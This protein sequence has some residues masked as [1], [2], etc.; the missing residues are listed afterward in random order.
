V[1]FD[2]SELLVSIN[3]GDDDREF[4]QAM[5][6]DQLHTWADYTA[7]E[8]VNGLEHYGF[9]DDHFAVAI[10]QDKTREPGDGNK[11]VFKKQVSQLLYESL[12]RAGFTESLNENAIEEVTTFLVNNQLSKINNTNIL[13]IITYL[14]CYDV[15]T[16]VNLFK[17]EMRYESTTGRTSAAAQYNGNISSITWKTSNQ[18]ENEYGH[19]Y[20]KLNRL[21]ASDYALKSGSSWTN[22]TN[23]D[24]NGISY[25][26]NGNLLSMTQYGKINTGN[27]YNKIDALTYR[28]DG[29]RLL[30]VTDSEPLASARGDFE[31][32]NK[33]TDD[34]SYDANGNLI[35]D[36]N[37]GINITYNYL[38]M[39]SKIVFANGNSIYYIYNTNGTKMR[40]LHTT[41]IA[42]PTAPV[43]Q[44]RTD[45]V[46]GFVYVNNELDFF[47]NETG[48]VLKVSGGFERQYVIA[49][50]LGNARMS[51][52]PN[53]N[54]QPV[55]L[56]YDSYYPFGL[57]MGGMSFVSSSE[58]KYKYNGK[59]KQTAHN[60]GWYDYGA[61]FY[62][63][64]IGRWHVVDP[65]AEKTHSWTPYR[66]GFNNPI[67]FI[68][69]DGRSEDNI[70]TVDGVEVH[71][72]VTNDNYD[73]TYVYK[74]N[75]GEASTLQ[76]I[77]VSNKDGKMKMNEFE[78]KEETKAC[79][80]CKN[81][82]LNSPAD[83]KGW[84]QMF[85]VES[86]YTTTEAGKWM[87]ENNPLVDTK[88]KRDR[89]TQINKEIGKNSAEEI[90][91][92]ATKSKGASGPIFFLP[93]LIENQILQFGPQQ[94]PTQT[95]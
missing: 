35:E 17:Q 94:M 57:E 19:T 89:L 21:V 43:T 49:D 48:R 36:K 9:T 75:Q 67:N 63:P 71:R 61:R 69:P 45:Y 44:T 20:D 84:D 66:Y 39:P 87:T 80:E 54:N 26:V 64:Q 93:A 95:Y 16:R 12:I 6:S 73:R 28:Y 34:Y 15:E 86:F 85:D 58:N 65:L 79:T 3:T 31:D 41:Q 22:P 82:R 38:N 24:V 59:E 4:Y 62:D 29:N 92:D 10:M 78:V 90:L 40:M 46:N 8:Y 81:G 30:A 72:E 70:T 14:N 55:I 88:E 5:L 23:Y 83:P 2:P 53:A 51:V 18:A 56:Q 7:V 74:T 27:T 50:H 47:A 52:K 33:N 60:L 13:P 11:E 77:E 91:K 76:R 37:K 1:L 68:D 25:D 42:S 32:H